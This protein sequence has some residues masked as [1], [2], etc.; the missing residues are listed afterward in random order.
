MDSADEQ[1]PFKFWG[2]SLGF[3]GKDPSLRFDFKKMK[4]G[5]LSGFFCFHGSTTQHSKL[6][7]QHSSLICHPLLHQF[8]YDML[9]ARA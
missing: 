9:A 2:L 1:S 5:R 4:S 3:E 8:F 7:T 6:I